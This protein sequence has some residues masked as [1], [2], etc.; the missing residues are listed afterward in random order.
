MQTPEI[1]YG[2]LIS[3]GR[4]KLWQ[5]RLTTEDAEDTKS[6]CFLCGFSNP[7]RKIIKSLNPVAANIFNQHIEHPDDRDHNTIAPPL[8]IN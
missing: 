7:S 3:F 6:C 5:R 1:L 2:F 4:I 8:H